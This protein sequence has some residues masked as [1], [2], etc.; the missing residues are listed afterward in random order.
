MFVIVRGDDFVVEGCEHDLDW[1]GTELGKHV[2]VNVR[3][4]VGPDKITSRTFLHE[5][6]H[7]GA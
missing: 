7:H 5:Q 1:F 4:I 3:G 6:G 2:L